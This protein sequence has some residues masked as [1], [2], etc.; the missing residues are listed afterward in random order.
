M[1][2]HLTACIGLTRTWCVLLCHPNAS[3]TWHDVCIESTVVNVLLARPA[4]GGFGLVITGGDVQP[5]TVLRLPPGKPAASCGMLEVGDRLVRI[6]NTPI[7]GKSL[8][9]VTLLMVGTGPPLDLEFT[10]Q[11]CQSCTLN[12]QQLPPGATKKN[13]TYIYYSN[14]HV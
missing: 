2:L 6:N 8:G 9:D 5:V 4:S 12:K 7:D 13:H 3:D 1:P 11:A 10:S 14:H